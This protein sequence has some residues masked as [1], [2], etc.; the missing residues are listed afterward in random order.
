MCFLHSAPPRA[1]ATSR[2][3]VDRTVESRRERRSSPRPPR[4]RPAPCT[5][6]PSAPPPDSSAKVRRVTRTDGHAQ[7]GRHPAHVPGRG[8]RRVSSDPQLRYH[9]GCD[10]S[11]RRRGRRARRGGRGDES[12][13]RRFERRTKFVPT[14]SASPTRRRRSPTLRSNSRRAGLEIRH[15]H[16]YTRVVPRALLRYTLLS[17]TPRGA[18]SSPVRSPPLSAHFFFVRALTSSS[19][20]PPR[21]C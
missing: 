21:S 12:S 19:S 13:R 4:A 8:Q 9:A 11:R 1:R 15:S 20:S 17:T 18:S 14:R 5:K 16:W 7:E 2:G 10:D 6:P 3:G